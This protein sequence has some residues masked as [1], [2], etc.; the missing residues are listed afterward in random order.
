[1]KVKT[2]RAWFH[3]G[4]TMLVD[5]EDTDDAMSIAR[6][7]SLTT[8]FPDG[9]KSLDDFRYAHEIAEVSRVS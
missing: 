7:Y 3:N 2:F 8:N 9:P 6:R 4:S 5:A 1:M